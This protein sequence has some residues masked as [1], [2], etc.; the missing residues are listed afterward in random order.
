MSQEIHSIKVTGSK[1]SGT[2][3]IVANKNA[4]LPSIIA[5]LLTTETCTFKKTP[6]SPDVLKITKSLEHLG[7]EVVWTSE[8]TLQITCKNI[9]SGI[10]PESI[11]GIQAAAL[12]AG[13]LLVRVGECRIP[14]SVGCKLGF[15][16]YE[17]HVDYLSA[18]GVVAEETEDTILFKTTNSQPAT[19]C[20]FMQPLVTPTENLLM[21]LSGV[22]GQEVEVSGIAQEPHVACLIKMLRL[23]G[24]TITGKGSIVS[25]KGSQ[26]LK[27][28]EIDFGEEP[29]QVDFFGVAVSILATKSD[30]DIDLG[31]KAPSSI[32]H[33]M[34][35]LISTGAVM[36][37]DENQTVVHVQ[38]SKSSFH[39][40]SSFPKAGESTWKLDPGPWPAFPVDCLPSFVTWACMNEQVGTKTVIQNWMYENG[41]RYG[42]NLRDMGARISHLEDQKIIVDGGTGNP[43]HRSTRVLA[44]EVIEGV[45]AVFI[46]ALAA[47]ETTTIEIERV[48]PILR[49]NPD[50]FKLYQQLGAKI[51]V[52]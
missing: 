19:Y 44:P 5:S 3:S 24:A 7:A 52:L 35:F 47:T 41:L 11:R 16:G 29:D 42:D 50:I 51:E 39:P 12:F 27:G 10:L 25:V 18:A 22:N 6:K 14:R 37:L 28:V 21:F 46:A 43:F 36:N 17:G 45:R 34:K 40:I 23:M 32:M 4:V 1:L 8:D 20:E 9:T 38:G 30:V 2:I 48:Q 33:M 15:R 13:P 49:R 31:C 26:D